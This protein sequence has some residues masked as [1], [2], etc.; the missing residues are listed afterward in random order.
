MRYET[1]TWRVQ[2]SAESFI[3]VSIQGCD[4][5]RSKMDPEVVTRAGHVLVDV[6]RA[7]ER[8]ARKHQYKVPAAA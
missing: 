4:S 7:M 6:G 3:E 2:V 8:L 5:D 1:A